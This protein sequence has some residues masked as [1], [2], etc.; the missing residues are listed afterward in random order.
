MEFP[1]DSIFLKYDGEL[2]NQ[3]PSGNGT[4]VYKNSDRYTGEWKY[5]KRHGTG[6]LTYS[7][8]DAKGRVYYSGDWENDKRSGVNFINV[9]C[10]AFTLVC[11]KSA[12]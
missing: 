2:L 6:T 12:K 7:N 10:A 8:D 11:P 5:G 1:E 4:M 3:K 9:L